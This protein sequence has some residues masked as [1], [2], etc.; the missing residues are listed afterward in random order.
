MRA[1]EHRSAGMIDRIRST[2]TIVMTDRSSVAGRT[3][4]SVR[5][6]RAVVSPQSLSNVFDAPR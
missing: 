4:V 2:V 6:E 1:L 5:A 3:V